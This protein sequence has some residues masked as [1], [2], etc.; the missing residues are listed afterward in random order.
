MRKKI[1]WL[2]AVVAVGVMATSVASAGVPDMAK[3]SASATLGGGNVVPA[4]AQP[5][6]F[7][8]LKLATATAAYNVT[9]HSGAAPRVPFQMLVWRGDNPPFY[10]KPGTM[11]YVPVLYNDDSPV[12]IGDFPDPTD[13]EAL[14]NYWYSQKQFGVVYT[15][16]TVDGK[17]MSLGP[18]YVMGVK[19]AAPLPD[20]ATQYITV[21]AVLTPLTKGRH[22]IGISALATGEAIG[23]VFEF[24]L[25]YTVIVK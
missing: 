11:L 2:F 5:K 18:D 16:I 3:H 1:L 17:V 8:L 20:T 21:G 15:N 7:S 14:L 9:D 10:V 23:G 13:R 25:D 4:V 6:G 24:A 12:I 19:F 22:T